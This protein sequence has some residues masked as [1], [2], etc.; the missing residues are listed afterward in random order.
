LGFDGIF[1][2]IGNEEI[3]NSV[4]QKATGPGD[5]NVHERCGAAVDKFVESSV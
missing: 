5:S 2:K 4:I 3:L 1:E